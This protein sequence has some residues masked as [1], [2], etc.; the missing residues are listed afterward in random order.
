[1]QAA[2][3]LDEQLVHAIGRHIGAGGER[4]DDFAAGVS[5]GLVSTD[6]VGHRHDPAGR[7]ELGR[8]R[9]GHTGSAEGA[10]EQTSV[11]IHLAQ[12]A[13]VANP[14]SLRC[15]MLGW[16]RHGSGDLILEH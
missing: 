4:G 14:G 2:I 1:V 10:A 6:A 11:L 8:H 15:E 5:A 16:F 12:F 13:H 3:G 7:V 9:G